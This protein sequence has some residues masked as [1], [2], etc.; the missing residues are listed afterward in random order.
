MKAII[1]FFKRFDY[2]IFIPTV[3][4]L[5]FSIFFIYSAGVNSYG[6]LVNNEWKKQLTWAIVGLL[7]F[8]MLTLVD[9]HRFKDFAT[10]TYVFN[11]VLLVAVLIFGTKISGAKRW[12]GIGSFGVQPAEFAKIGFILMLAHFLSNYGRNPRRRSTLL[13][14][15][16][17][18]LLPMSLILI[19]PD[20]GTAMVFLG[21]LVF[22]FFM[23]GG[24]SLLLVF[25]ILVAFWIIFLIFFPLYFDLIK[26]RD[27]WLTTLFSTPRWLIQLI[28]VVIMV[29][30]LSL[31]GWMLY[32]KWAYMIV[33][34]FFS[35]FGVALVFTLL[36]YLQFKPYQWDRLKV[37]V[38]PH[39]DP[40]GSGWHI[41]Q[42]LMA[43][44][45]GGMYGRGYLKGIHSHNRYLPEQ[46]TD[47]IFSIVMEETGFVGAVILLGLYA[48]LLLR[49][50]VI[51]TKTNDQFSML[52]VCGVFSLLLIH[53]WIN[54]GMVIG[55]MPIKG[56]PL[57]LLSYGGSS[58]WS[59][60]MLLGL[61]SSISL[62]RY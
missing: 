32:R 59:M 51:M 37:F 33:L 57:F 54:V 41:L 52:V 58:V 12:L 14:S 10:I 17:I 61:V 53:V 28:L 23:A 45:S 55:L 20:F 49:L 44:G 5:T 60:M 34:Y 38:N 43:I 26:E 46:S 42:S 19:Q 62:R 18:L 25:F 15:I 35:S 27:I 13:I 7:F 56:V 48:I 16:V 30:S 29:V 3:I 21:I 1:D 47:F 11:L 31:V 9:Y 22:M 40:L 24:S 36:A 8:F 6:I 2:F 50:L 39:I 4:L